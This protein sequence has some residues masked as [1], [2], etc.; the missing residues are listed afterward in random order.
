IIRGEVAPDK[1]TE[2]QNRLLLD[3][4]EFFKSQLLDWLG[5]TQV[6][7]RRRLEDF[8]TALKRWLVLVEIRLEPDDD[9]QQIFETLNSLGTPLLN[10]DLVKNLLFRGLADHEAAILYE[11]T[12]RRFEDRAIFWRERVRQ[13]RL[14]SP[15]IDLF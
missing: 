8:L 11:E 15:R 3:A 9:P 5:E 1:P 6:D 4:G 7:E 10:A 14:L 13:G 2:G 12:W